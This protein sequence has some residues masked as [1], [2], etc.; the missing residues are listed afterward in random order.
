MAMYR[1]ICMIRPGMKLVRRKQIVNQ[2]LVLELITSIFIV[3]YLFGGSA[4]LLHYVPFFHN[5]N[6]H[7]LESMNRIEKKYQLL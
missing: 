7:S 6:G 4:Y 1:I 2:L 3:G 5:F